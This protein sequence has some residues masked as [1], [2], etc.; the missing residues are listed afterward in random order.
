[1]LP[2]SARTRLHRAFAL[3]ATCVLLACGVLGV[4]H[5][6]DG[7]HVRDP[8]TGVMLHAHAMTG[9]HVQSSSPDVHGRAEDHDTDSGA[10]TL[11]DAIHQVATS[12]SVAPML[13]LP[14]VS[15]SVVTTART[16]RDVASA[17]VLRDAPKTSPPVAS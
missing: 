13:S 3:V 9:A 15:T 16:D 14:V 2:R 12:A 8:L 4:R 1:M 7:A 5:Q 10:C 6:A 17:S 11:D